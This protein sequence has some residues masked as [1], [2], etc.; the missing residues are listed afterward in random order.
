MARIIF[1]MRPREIPSLCRGWRTPDPSPSRDLGQKPAPIMTII[2]EESKQRAEEALAKGFATMRTP[3]HS[4]DPLDFCVQD[5]VMTPR[6]H[7]PHITAWDEEDGLCRQVTPI[8]WQQAIPE[9]ACAP[10]KDAPRPL[11]PACTK[12]LQVP[13]LLLSD[14]LPGRGKERQYTN[15]AS[16][17]ETRFCES[18]AIAG[19]TRAR[20]NTACSEQ[21]GLQTPQ[22]SWSENHRPIRSEQKLKV[23]SSKNPK[24][25][26]SKGS[27]GHPYSCAEA[28]KYA[29]KKKGC[30]DGAFCDHCHLCD[31]KRYESGRAACR[32]AARSKWES[33]PVNLA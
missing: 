6:G 32:A 23:D 13:P 4:P 12:R 24:P 20:A 8:F 14:M 10:E 26:V 7:A 22:F 31:W 21:Q 9:P 28:C 27:V 29:K 33:K 16:T 11:I 2:E 25:P 15:P 1:E 30:K 19:A 18:F 3:S 17:G 5:E